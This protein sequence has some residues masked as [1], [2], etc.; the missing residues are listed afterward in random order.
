MD[1]HGVSKDRREFLHKSG[2]VLSFTL[3]TKF[4]LLT[5]AEARAQDLPLKV[6]TPVEAETLGAVAEALVPGALDSGIVHY[7]DHQLSADAEDS[8]LMLQ[9][10]GVPHAGFTGFYRAALAGTVAAAQARFEA[11]WADLNE[12]QI[13]EIAGL[14]NGPDP[15]AWTGPPSGFFSFVLRGD[16]CDVVY[17][18]EAGFDR[19]GMPYMAHIRPVSPW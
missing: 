7:I 3:G 12:A 8:L 1:A 10:L 19:I 18:T 16:A 11:N 5:P 9:Y 15:L 14:L 13:T 2:L 17:G 6:L 4:L